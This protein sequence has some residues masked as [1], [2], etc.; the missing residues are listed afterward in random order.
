[1][2]GITVFFIAALFIV[3]FAFNIDYVDLREEPTTKIKPSGRYHHDK[4]GRSL[5]HV[6]G[7]KILDNYDN[8]YELFGTGYRKHP[9]SDWVY[10]WDQNNKL[11]LLRESEIRVFP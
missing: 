8:K 9:T 7:Y 11:K 10:L 5:R 2:A 6:R 4:Y 1:M 3:I